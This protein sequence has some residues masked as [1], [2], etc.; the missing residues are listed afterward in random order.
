[1]M[2]IIDL[3]GTCQIGFFL[4]PCIT[5]RY[6]CIYYEYIKYY[7][8]HDR[9]IYLYNNYKC[10]IITVY[11]LGRVNLLYN[12]QTKYIAIY[13]I[14]FLYLISF[15]ALAEVKSTPYELVAENINF[16]YQNG[17]VVASGEVIF[18]TE[19]L[20]IRCEDLVV[21]LNNNI[22]QARG[23]SIFLRLPGQEVTGTYLE[24]DYRNN[25]GKMLGAKTKLNELN[26]KGGVIKLL[27]GSEEDMEIEKASFTPCVFPDPHYQVKAKKIR[28]YKDKKIVAEQVEFWFEGLRLF[29]LPSYVVEYREGEEGVELYNS[30]PLPRLSYNTKTGISIEYYYPYQFADRGQG[31]FM[32]DIDQ[33]GNQDTIL[34][35]TYQ[36]SPSFE[37]TNR[38]AYNRVTNEKNPSIIEED[39]S[40]ASIGTNYRVSPEVTWKN[41]LQYSKT[42]EEGNIKEKNVFTTGIS[43][44][45][46]NYSV[47]TDLGYDFINKNREESINIGYT[48]FKNY[49]LG[50]YHQYYNELLEKNSYVLSHNGRPVKWKITQRLGYDIDYQPYLEFNFPEYNNFVSINSHLGLG[51]VISGEIETEK[52][53]SDLRISKLVKIG[54]NFNIDLS[55]RVIDNRYVNPVQSNYRVYEGEIRGKSTSKLSPDLTLNSSLGYSITTDWGIPYLPDDEV[56]T[57]N[58]LVPDFNL[59]IKTEEPGSALLLNLNGRYI[60]EHEEW[61]EIKIKLTRKYD[62]Y[63]Y[64]IDYNLIDSS[65]GFGFSM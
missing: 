17:R 54:Q 32:V 1:M 36:V 22:V 50:I 51:K 63:S 5:C 13:L 45:R 58:Y 65:F 64:F 27:K 31:K 44:N 25:T 33:A 9:K 16:D 11:D 29:T 59:T 6:F 19:E 49:Y 21:D 30:F 12:S 20:I 60:I 10:I 53:R 8:K 4:L 42:I 2:L 37:I 34:T 14:I 35:N 55:G 47:L 7:R 57:G 26:F 46:D 52:V 24:F 39:K 40:V 43:Y 61:E 23:K 38:L 41:N 15:T 28:V 48:P 62:C 56:E 3:F 18:E